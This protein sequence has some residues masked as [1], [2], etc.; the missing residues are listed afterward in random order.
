MIWLYRHRRTSRLR[1]G[2]LSGKGLSCADH[3][4]T[5]RMPTDAFTNL[6]FLRHYSIIYHLTWKRV[7]EHRKP[8]RIYSYIVNLVFIFQL[9]TTQYRCFSCLL[10]L[11][12]VYLLKL[13]SD[14]TLAGAT[15]GID[16][17]HL[18]SDIKLWTNH[19]TFLVNNNKVSGFL[20]IWF[21]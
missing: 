13:L 7:E 4:N 17:G 14:R 20:N 15:H 19:R 12:L 10:L 21:H 1:R 9:P 6:T 5:L 8:F 3:S 16:I 11:L 2:S 18:A